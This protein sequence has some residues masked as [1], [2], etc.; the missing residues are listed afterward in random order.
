ME[1]RISDG[2]MRIGSKA[3]SEAVA[4]SLIRIPPSEI[5]IP[6]RGLFHRICGKACGKNGFWRYK[7]LTTLDF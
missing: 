7:F 6:S 3:D 4:C 1:M 2:G 5:R